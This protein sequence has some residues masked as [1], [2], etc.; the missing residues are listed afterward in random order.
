MHYLEQCE[1]LHIDNKYP[2]AFIYDTNSVKELLG[3]EPDIFEP[4]LVGYNEEYIREGNEII[5][6]GEFPYDEN[7]QPAL[8]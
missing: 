2:K 5:I 6:G 8:Q 4:C 1:K 3:E 7:K